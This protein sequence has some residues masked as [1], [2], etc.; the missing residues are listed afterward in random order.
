[1]SLQIPGGAGSGGGQLEPDVEMSDLDKS[2][3]APTA[4]EKEKKE[5]EGGEKKKRQ[6]GSFCA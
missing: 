5:K 3:H 6:E 4:A 1:M 2:R